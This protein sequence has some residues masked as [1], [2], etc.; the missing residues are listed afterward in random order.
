MEAGPARNDGGEEPILAAREAAAIARPVRGGARAAGRQ[1][2]DGAARA[3][4][5]RDASGRTRLR[6]LYQ[7]G[8]AKIRLP[9]I[10]DGPP[11]AVL[12]N[13]A[14]GLT[15]GDRLSYE[16]EVEAGARAVIA[17]QTAE[18]IYKALPD[19]GAARVENRLILGPGAAL[20]WLAQE[21]ILFEGGRLRRSMTVEMAEDARL[22]AVEP[23]ALGREA[24]GERVATGA[25]YDIWRIRRGGKLIYA[26]AL[27]LAEPIADR[28]DRLAAL[29][30]DRAMASLLIVAPEGAD[31]LEAVR[32]ALGDLGAGARAAASAV[33]GVIAARLTAPSGGV[34][35]RALAT[36]LERLRGAPAPRVWRC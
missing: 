7:R 29:G 1:R 36:A 12:L 35:M 19:E 13:T 9:R 30:G 17:T 14:G 8:A 4:F 5:Y 24:M 33:E 21:T 27:R 11:E 2:V 3:S 6:D 32:A 15:S 18:R 22:L 31:R 10:H 26:D 20:D 25:Y 16:A 28:M 23:L 34:L